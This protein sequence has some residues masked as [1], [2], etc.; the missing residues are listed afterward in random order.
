MHFVDRPG[1]NCYDCCVMDIT[2]T[3]LLDFALPDCERVIDLEPPL[4]VRGV[5][6]ADSGKTSADKNHR[7]LLYIRRQ[8]G[9]VMFNCGGERIPFATNLSF[10]EIFNKLEESFTT[11]RDWDM[12]L[13]QGIIEKKGLQ[14]ILDVSD[15]IFH[16]P[17]ALT[18][19][20]HKLLAYTK[21]VQEGDSI[22]VSLTEKGYLPADAIARMDQAGFI[23]ENKGIV[24]RRG[25]EGLSFPMLNGTIFIGQD[26]R[27]MLTMLLPNDDLPAGVLDLFGILINQL[28]LYVETNG[29]ASRIRSFAWA[30]LLADLIEGKCK[31]DEFTERNRYTGLP[32][33]SAWQLVS[34]RREDGAMREFIRDRLDQAL[35][36]DIVFIQGNN[37]LI[38]L[39]DADRAGADTNASAAGHSAAGHLAAEC[40]REAALELAPA[41]E[42]DQLIISISNRFDTLLDLN[43]AYAQTNAACGLGTRISKNRIL[44]KL[45]VTSKQYDERVF[46]Y[47]D[48]YQY[49]MVSQAPELYPPFCALLEEDKKFA[50]GNLRLL[51][52]YL[53]NDCSKTRTAA[54]L[55]MHRNNI[56]YRIGKMEEMLGLS[57]SDEQEKTSFRLSF[58]ALE[59]LE[60]PE[61]PKG[62]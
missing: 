3:M 46:C 38:V 43:K 56:I 50:S 17:M 42:I 59:L 9:G 58:L 36:N 20:G 52:A 18:D 31:P 44:E 32:E 2:L 12:R 35:H 41:I 6:I 39:M 24:H 40:I 48:Y 54:E 34:I 14:Y 57:L 15:E 26:Y 13:H 4:Y 37:V 21:R 61:S 51:Y 25:I 55:F 16:R 30:S 23:F 47:S 10:A 27:Y 5:R 33:G 49:D 8:A 45:G 7:E 60:S 1:A 11:L 29:D 62:E 28:T 19:S 22:Y 53:K